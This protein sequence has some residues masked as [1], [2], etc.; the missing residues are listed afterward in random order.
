[1]TGKAA[2]GALA[3]VLLCIAAGA[4]WISRRGPGECTNTVSAER[5]SPG[6]QWMAAVFSR[7][8]GDGETT[9]VA[10]RRAGAPFEPANDDVVFVAA[11][12][13]PL[14]LSWTPEPEGLVIETRAGAVAREEH[15]WRKLGVTVRR[16]R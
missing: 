12:R 3:A 2:L 4:S 11:G 5:R 13:E 8:C 16:V 10:L 6:G 15:A 7:R 14:K 1:V 9:Q